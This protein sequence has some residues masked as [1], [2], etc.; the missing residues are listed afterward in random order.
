MRRSQEPDESD[1][2]LGKSKESVEPEAPVKSVR[3]SVARES[4]YQPAVRGG[5]DC[6][7]RNLHAIT[8]QF[9]RRHLLRM[10]EG[11]FSPESCPF[12]D[13]S[14]SA[15]PRVGRL[16][17]SKD[18]KDPVLNSSLI[19]KTEDSQTYAAEQIMSQQRG[20]SCRTHL[21]NQAVVVTKMTH[22]R[23]SNDTN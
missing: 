17:N 15:P 4:Q 2:V 9:P 16:L 11:H 1:P 5:E 12:T 20:E 14:I 3:F 13:D 6:S 7:T 22:A 10:Q 18:C 23:K 21:S 19:S 8:A